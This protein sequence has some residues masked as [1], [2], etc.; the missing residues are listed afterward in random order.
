MHV[1]ELSRES[2]LAFVQV[3]VDDNAETES[4]TEIQKEHVFLSFGTALHI[5][6][7]CHG[8]TVVIDGDIA[9]HLFADIGVQRHFGEVVKAITVARIGVHPARDIDVD[10]EHFLTRYL[11]MFDE[12]NDAIAEF[13]ERRLCVVGRERLIVDEVDQVSAEVHE[14]DAER[15][16]LHVDSNKI[17]RVG[18]EPVQIGPS[19][20]SRL[21]LAVFQDIS[22]C[23]HLVDCLGHCGDTQ[24][25]LLGQI[26]R[27]RIAILDKI[28]QNI[29]FQNNILAIFFFFKKVRHITQDIYLWPQIY[30]IIC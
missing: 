30:E 10:V 19:A 8:P 21:Q 1:A 3:S 5:F 15:T 25:E 23:T 2:R 20:L 29:A 9:A 4:P 13:V 14:T 18:I 22:S 11:D 6:A 7:V 24:V 26:V 27:G 17:A 12:T 16:L 28:A